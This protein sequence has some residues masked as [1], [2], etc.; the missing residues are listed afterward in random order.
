VL[1]LDFL[2]ASDAGADHDAGAENIHL[3]EIKSAVLDGLIRCGHGELSEAVHPLA[4]SPID[5]FGYIEILCLAPEAHWIR[6]RI[7][8]FYQGDTALAL[9]QRREKLVCGLG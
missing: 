8:R 3:R 9:A 2:D 1:V 4:L 7:K 6:A 5:I